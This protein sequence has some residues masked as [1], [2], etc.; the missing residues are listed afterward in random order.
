[1]EKVTKIKKELHFARVT[2]NVQYAAIEPSTL[3]PSKV[4]M[5]FSEEYTVEHY[6]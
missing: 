4:D 2:W 1:M 5:Q 6:R 3:E